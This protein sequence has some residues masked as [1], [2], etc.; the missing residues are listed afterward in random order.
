[1][2]RPLMVVRAEQQ[3]RFDTDYYVEGVATTFGTP[4]ELFEM[5]GKKYYEVID[6]NALVGADMSDI[7]M[8]FDHRGKVL[9]RISNRTLGFEITANELK[10][11][12]D[13]SKSNAAKEMH[14]EIKN[15]LVTKMSWAF[16]M[17]EDGW[18][19]DAS[20]RT[21]TITRITKVYDFAPVSFPAN[22][23]TEISARD[24]EFDGVIERSAF[25]DGVIEGI[26][27]EELARKRKI[28]LINLKIETGR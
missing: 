25:L 6:R 21:W 22:D 17:A 14:E 15:G 4:Y 12:A 24:S 10:I 18:V 11:F 9:A 13:L 27:R 19:Y 16:R 1:M 3:K 20:T 23:F 8:R 28:M 26:R 7:I 2:A 5:N